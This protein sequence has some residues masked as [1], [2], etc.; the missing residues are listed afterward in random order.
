MN[1]PSKDIKLSKNLNQVSKSCI[2]D[3]FF[4]M[5]VQKQKINKQVFRRT[6]VGNK[7]KKRYKATD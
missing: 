7:C 3:I 5:G 2:F 4:R 1:T 6:E